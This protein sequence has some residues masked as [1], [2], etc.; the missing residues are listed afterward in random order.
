[1]KEKKKHLLASRTS[2]HRKRNGAARE[3]KKRKKE[4]KEKK[5]PKTW[6]LRVKKW[7]EKE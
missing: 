6:I 1:M 7:S 2:F 5:D 4:K 3:R